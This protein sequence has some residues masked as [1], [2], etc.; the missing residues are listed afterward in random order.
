M[1]KV[2]CNLCYQNRLN[3]RL[4]H[5]TTNHLLFNVYHKNIATAIGYFKRA[6]DGTAPEDAASR[7]AGSSEASSHALIVGGEE[8]ALNLG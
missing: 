3:K 5:T 1:Q 7:A 4:K 2:T 8:N 6:R